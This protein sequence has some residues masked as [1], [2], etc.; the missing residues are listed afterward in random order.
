MLND[1]DEIAAPAGPFATRNDHHEKARVV[2]EVG[3]YERLGFRIERQHTESS[4]IRKY[5]DSR[6]LI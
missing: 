3:A 1:D 6:A 4:P 5:V 2:T